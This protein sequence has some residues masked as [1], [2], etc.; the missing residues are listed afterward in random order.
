MLS[1]TRYK[2]GISLPVL[3]YIAV[4]PKTGP[5]GSWWEPVWALPL[6]PFPKLWLPSALMFYKIWASL[7]THCSPESLKVLFVTTFSPS[8]LFLFSFVR[9]FVLSSR[10]SPQLKSKTQVKLFPPLLYVGPILIFIGLE[11]L[12]SSPWFWTQSKT[13]SFTLFVFLIEFLTLH[14]WSSKW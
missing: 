8:R 7:I 4:V 10:L 9:S 11:G 2:N 13:L 12:F 3:F 1:K 14:F 6:V 5:L